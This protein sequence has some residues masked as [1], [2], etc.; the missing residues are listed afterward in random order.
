M[1][2]YLNLESR[3][4]NVPR[5]PPFAE[6]IAVA[7]KNQFGEYIPR[8][9]VAIVHQDTLSSNLFHADFNATKPGKSIQSHRQPSHV[10]C[11]ES[12]RRVFQHRPAFLSTS[13]SSNH[14]NSSITHL[15]DSVYHTL[16]LVALQVAAESLDSTFTGSPSE[17]R[18][19][20]VATFCNTEQDL[21]PE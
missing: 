21:R 16:R 8:E 17:I 7:K 14:I 9:V 4:R 3:R 19:E 11:R 1:L 15:E 5:L 10:R 2:Q 12:P 20:T 18:R 6:V 13:F